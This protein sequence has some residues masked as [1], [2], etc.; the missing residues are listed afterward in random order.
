M[1][2]ASLIVVIDPK[3]LPRRV[4][5]D[6]S[7]LICAL[8]PN[9]RESNAAEFRDLFDALLANGKTILIAAPSLSE[10]L[11]RPEASPIPHREGI[12][13]VPFDGA[14]ARLLAERLPLTVIVQAKQK[15]PSNYIKYDAM[16]VAC[17][18]RHRADFLITKDGQQTTIA[19]SANLACASFQEFQTQQLGL[20]LA[21]R[22]KS[23]L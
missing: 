13:V 15:A 3:R 21:A 12:V 2:F 16:I 23:Y 17:A 10:L 1:Y 18:L 4:M 8:T 9:S 19:Q 7:T 22:A 20:N 14:A 6:S 11:R 5:F